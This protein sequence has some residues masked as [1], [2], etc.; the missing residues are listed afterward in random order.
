MEIPFNL[1]Q[2]IKEQ[3]PLIHCITNPISI[4]QCANAILALGALP[5]T[6]EHP[7]EVGEITPTADALL[8]NLGNITDARIKSAKIAI[9]TA[10]KN[11]IPVVL[12]AVGV[13]C[14]ALRLKLAKKLLKT[15]GVG[16][17]KG[18][19]SEINA[20]AHP[21][22]KS[23]GVDASPTLTAEGIMP[24]CQDLAAKYNCVILASGKRDIVCSK[25]KTVLIENGTPALGNITGTGCMQGAIVAT[26][27]SHGKHFEA[28]VLGALTLGIC[29]EMAEGEGNYLANLM[30]QI[31][32]ITAEDIK[33]R[34]EVTEIEKL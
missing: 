33:T 3:K 20:L 34:M 13:A 24:V 19:Y 2:C 25:D 12:D 1:L 22:Y 28:A 27:A 21:H 8:I 16:I 15:G 23:A 29:G 6:A 5:I 30:N 31:G 11:S 7:K 10:K 17:L 26:F 14:S 4:T 9:K 32:K 18:N